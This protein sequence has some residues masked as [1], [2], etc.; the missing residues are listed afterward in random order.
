[1][2]NSSAP[3]GGSPRGNTFISTGLDCWWRFA[4]RYIARIYPTTL[5]EYLVLGS[6]YHAFLEGTEEALIATW[7]GTDV[8]ATAKRLYEK[9]LKDGPPL[10]AALAVEQTHEI[11][12]GQMTSKPDR[13]EAGLVRDYKTAMMWSKHDQQHWDIEPGILGEMVAAGVKRALVDV[14]KKEKSEAD[15]EKEGEVKVFTVELTDAKAE[16]LKNHVADFWWQLR[17]RLE[18]AAKGTKGTEK[19]TLAAAF[20]KNLKN[21]IGKYGICAYYQR[22]WGKGA[23]AFLFVTRDDEERRWAKKESKLTH[24]LLDRLAK[25]VEG[26][27]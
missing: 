14:V 13:E 20:P 25:L 17:A 23:T 21:C 2:K 6:A 19:A 10:G 15:A 7:Y 27:R 3:P 18:R 11:L 4:L 26:M 9:R 16:A 8:T 12:G 5:P 22:C 1:M 24:R